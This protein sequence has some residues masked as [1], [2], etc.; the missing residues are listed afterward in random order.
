MAMVLQSRSAGK[1]S[2]T[3]LPGLFKLLSN[4]YLKSPI[5]AHQR[6]AFGLKWSETAISSFHQTSIEWVSSAS[7]DQRTSKVRAFRRLPTRRTRGVHRLYFKGFHIP[8]WLLSCKKLQV[9]DPS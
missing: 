7:P 9:L 6:G 5:V 3:A 4:I 8:S 1:A 2:G